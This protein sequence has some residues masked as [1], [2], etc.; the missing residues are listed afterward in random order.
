MVLPL[1]RPRAISRKEGRC[2]IISGAFIAVPSGFQLSAYGVMFHHFFNETHP[3]GQG[4]ISA[5]E[6]EAIL[7]DLGRDNILPPDEW[8]RRALSGTL[9]EADIC[10][11]FDDAL[12]CQYDVA[13]PVLKAMNLTA[14]WFVY[15]G[16]FQGRPEV[17]E[18][19]RHF[20]TTAFA[21]IDG[22]H[23]EFVDGA[24]ALF[25]QAYASALDD[26]DAQSYL[27]DYPFY[28][29]GD[30]QFRYLRDD[31]LGQ[32]RY[33]AVMAFLMRKKAFDPQAVGTQLWMS[34]DE[35]RTLDRDGHVIGLHSFSHPTR[36]AELSPAAQ[37]DEYR[38]NFVHLSATLGKP[39]T[40]MS[41]PCNSYSRET[42]SILQDMGIKLGFRS[43]MAPI[44]GASVF[45][46]P[47]QDQANLMTALKAKKA[48]F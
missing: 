34:D 41:H 46:F 37:R 47:R 3:G 1:W 19:Y 36:L 10:L 21:D 17:L 29:K 39:P 44:E 9:G 48:D 28:T 4:A 5:N 38:Q 26:F 42:V 30:R 45:E 8:Q 31:V 12:K 16:V 11:T 35:I 32:Q 6:L 27:A 2:P 13:V 40:A 25:P 18:I 15:S 33:Q 43:N 22:F 7:D 23:E 24:Q 14:F 20:R